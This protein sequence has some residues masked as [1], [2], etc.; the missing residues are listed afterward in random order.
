MKV[1]NIFSR[2]NK[3]S[4]NNSEFL[5]EFQH[6]LDKSITEEKTQVLMTKKLQSR[7]KQMV[8]VLLHNGFSIDEINVF[9][10]SNKKYIMKNGEIMDDLS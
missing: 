5:N 2:K 3:D 1:K 6:T 8:K 4:A 10:N 9:I 7:F